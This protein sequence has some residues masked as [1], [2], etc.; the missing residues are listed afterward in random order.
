MYPEC[1]LIFS[2]ISKSQGRDPGVE[3]V[4]ALRRERDGLLY[5]H[6]GQSWGVLIVRETKEHLG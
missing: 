5:F 4:F 3:I 6:K 2:L 1:T